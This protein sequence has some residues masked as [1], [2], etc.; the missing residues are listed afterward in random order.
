V[1]AWMNGLLQ[2]VVEVVAAA[3]CGCDD[4]DMNN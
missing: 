1:A 2:A 3:G 4:L